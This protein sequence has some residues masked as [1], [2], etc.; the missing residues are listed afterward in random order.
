[1]KNW[2]LTNIQPVNND[3]KQLK[4]FTDDDVFRRIFK[5]LL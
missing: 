4:G 1:M 2:L 5:S 3:K